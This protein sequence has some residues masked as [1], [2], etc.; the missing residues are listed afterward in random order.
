[1]KKPHCADD[2]EDEIALL[3]RGGKVAQMKGFLKADYNTC[4]LRSLYILHV[5]DEVWI[6][7]RNLGHFSWFTSNEVSCRMIG[8]FAL[9]MRERKVFL[10]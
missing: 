7:S 10:V 4:A 1:M 3:R 6:H 9:G 8:D 5:H 2:D